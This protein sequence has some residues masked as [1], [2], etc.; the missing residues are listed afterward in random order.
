MLKRPIGQRGNVVPRTVRQDV[1]FA[2]AKDHAVAELI[3]GEV[4]G[5]VVCIELVERYVGHADRADFS[6]APSDP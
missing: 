5:P 6:L 2:I 3:A 4:A 1:C